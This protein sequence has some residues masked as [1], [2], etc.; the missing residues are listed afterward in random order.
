MALCGDSYG[1]H[2]GVG[3]SAQ[4]HAA[5]CFHSQ[6]K[7][8]HASA[9]LHEK[10]RPEAAP[11]LQSAPSRQVTSKQCKRCRRIRREQKTA[12]EHA[13]IISISVM[14]RLVTM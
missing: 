6:D 4:A 13:K 1:T 11:R 3:Y 5:P 8:P 7:T 14:T 10:Q 9:S 2:G 12:V